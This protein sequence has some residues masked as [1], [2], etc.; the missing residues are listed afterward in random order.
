MGAQKMRIVVYD[1]LYGNTRSVAQAIGNA[2]PGEVEVLHVGDVQAADLGAYDLLV[3]GAP[4]HG[5]RA[6][7]AI[8]AFLEQ[9]QASALKGVRVAGFDTRMTHKLARLLGFAAPKIAKALKQK[10]GTLAGPP[11]GFYVIGGEGPLKEGELKRA[12]AW[13]KQLALRGT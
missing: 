11:G 5:G 8:R 6:S 9:I 2:I 10:G 4:T 13:A 12:A 7:D 1:S 3:V